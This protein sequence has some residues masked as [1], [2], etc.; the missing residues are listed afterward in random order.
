MYPQSPSTF[1]F[2][3]FFLLC[4]FY[5]SN[6]GV[7]A[8]MYMNDPHVVEL[9]KTTFKS[10]VSEGEHTTIVKFYAPWCGHCKRLHKDYSKVGAELKSKATVAAVDCTK[11][12]D[13]C[14]E[15]NINGYPTMKVFYTKANS[16]KRNKEE[17][18]GDRSVSAIVD[19][20]T[21]LIPNH[22]KSLGSENGEMTLDAFYALMNTTLPKVLITK[23]EKTDTKPFIIYLATEFRF[24]LLFGV[25]VDPKY[26]KGDLFVIPLKGEPI[27]YTG[28]LK[29]DKLKSF[30]SQYAAPKKVEAKASESHDE[31]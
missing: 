27:K 31:L 6:H 16:L 7:F 15:N 24:K 8:N 13:L 11:H 4:S 21:K 12:E 3:V 5:L 18:Y 23:P 14:R 10:M 2:L 28:E 22:V 1:S 19:K 29:V 17:Y 26:G 25:H 20:V 30:L 9:D